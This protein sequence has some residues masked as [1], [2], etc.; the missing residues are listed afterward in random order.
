MKI[1]KTR[2]KGAKGT[3]PEKLPNIL[4]AYKTTTRVLMGETPFKLT[5]GS[6]VV[7]PVEVGLTSI[8]MKTFE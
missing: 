2:L 8:R 4:L 7:I 1:V 5:F 6:K 3:W